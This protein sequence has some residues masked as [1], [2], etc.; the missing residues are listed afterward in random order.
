MK[1]ATWNVERLRHKNALDQMLLACEQAGADI[2]VLTE[3]SQGICPCYKYCFQTLPASEINAHLYGEQE[4]RVSVFTN[5]RLVCRHPTYDPYTALCVE[6]ETEK[7]RLLVYGTIIGV[8]GNRHPGFKTDLL[9]QTA[10]FARLSNLADGLCIC[11]DLNCSFADS[12]YYTRYGR[13]TLLQSFRENGLRLLT[14]GTAECIDHIAISERFIG[15]VESHIDE[16]NL[17]RKLSDH[18]G[19]AVTFG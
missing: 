3:T 18:K 14:G 19:I 2:L 9:K 11:G 15:D 12:Y 16:W 5:Y 13:D 8:Y 1:I 17:G 7:G 10:D 6:L 4:N